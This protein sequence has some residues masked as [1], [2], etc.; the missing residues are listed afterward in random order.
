M[1]PRL[2]RAAGLGLFAIVLAAALPARAEPPASPRLGLEDFLRRAEADNPILRI[3]RAGLADYSAK[4]DRAYYA[5]LP[6]LKVD[7]VLAPLPERRLLRECVFGTDPVSA[8]PLIIPCPGQD[9]EDDEQITADTEIGILVKSSARLTFPIYTFGKVEAGQRAARAGLEIGEA[10]IDIARAGL[11]YEVK[12]AYYG[13]QLTHAALEVLRD[14]RSRIAD[15]K[16]TIERELKKESGRFTS[17]DLREL[18]LQRA[19]IEG[20]LLETESLEA[21]AW[22]GLRL[23]GGFELGQAFELDSLEIEPVHVE[24]RSREAYVELASVSRPDLRLLGAAVRARE[25]Q[26]DLARANFLPDIALVGGFGFAKG[27]TAEDSPDPFADDNYNYLSWGVVLGAEVSLDFAVLIGKLGEAQAALSKQR[28]ERDGLLLKVRLE[29]VE[30]YGAMERYRKELAIREEAMK[31]GKALLVS[32][33]LNFGAGLDTTAE[34]VLNALVKFSKA[35][36]KHL[37]TIYEF[38]LAVARLSR[39]VGVDL[40]VPRPSADE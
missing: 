35:R 12:R 6:S 20:S 8:L 4:F 26:V 28:A 32:K 19:D 31:A 33:T 21:V 34:D 27:T 7:A 16:Q 30:R 3:A 9:I 22:E 5:W 11:A 1:H 36:L 18:V 37:Q 40:A 38:N 23:A 2:P 29:V 14:G 25:N 13:A 15:I 24:P 17:N 39:T 10:G